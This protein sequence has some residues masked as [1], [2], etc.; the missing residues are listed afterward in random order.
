MAFCLCNNV[1]SDEI[2]GTAPAKQ[3]ALKATVAFM[4]LWE[5]YIRQHWAVSYAV[6]GQTPSPLL[7]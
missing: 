4:T 7:R 6:G 1:L 3:Q 5:S 2:L